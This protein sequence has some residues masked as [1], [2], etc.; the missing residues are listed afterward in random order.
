MPRP[1]SN[2]PLKEYQSIRV[3]KDI[4]N[5]IRRIAELEDR[6]IGAIVRRAMKAYAKQ[7]KR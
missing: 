2:Q 4:Y 6:S 3:E 5:E 1:P 7:T